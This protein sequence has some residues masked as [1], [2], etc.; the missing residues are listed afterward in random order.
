MIVRGGGSAA[1]WVRVGPAPRWRELGGRASPSRVRGLHIVFARPK[2]DTLILCYHAVS[3]D[4]PTDYVVTAADLERQIGHLLARGYRPVT[5]AEAAR[6]APG[7]VMAV[8]FDDAYASIAECAYPILARLG[9]PGTVFVPTDFPDR[10]DPMCWPGM[11]R[12][13]D[14]P[15][16]DELLPASW[17]QLQR[18]AEA[19]WEVASHTRSHRAL[20]SLSDADLRA[21]LAGSRSALVQRIGG[22][23]GSLSYPFGT[24]DDRVVRFAR[25]AGYTAAATLD[26]RLSAPS[27]LTIPRIGIYRGEGM[28]V[29]RLKVSPT[30]RRLR[31][32]TPGW[33]LVTAV[34]RVR[35]CWVAGGTVRG[36]I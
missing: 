22:S 15:H 19:G 9:V 33:S 36:L 29:F 14:G 1:R 26:G 35:R 16:E 6:G 23:C 3:E 25:S 34:S 10:R 5:F 21:E 2:G 31:A 13:L 28:G 4:W 30:V 17:H 8:T 7:R 18:L 11:E 32:R 20:T 24:Y 12:W 27:P